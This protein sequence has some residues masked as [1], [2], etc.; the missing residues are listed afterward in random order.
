MEGKKKE[1]RK[2]IGKEEEGADVE[3]L[4]KIRMEKGMKNGKKDNRDGEKRKRRR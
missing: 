1:R 3:R 2:R 4:G